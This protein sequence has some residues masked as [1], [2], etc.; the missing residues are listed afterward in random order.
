M[1][2]LMI[3]PFLNGYFIGKINPTFPDKPIFHIVMESG[4]VSCWFLYVEMGVIMTAMTIL[5]ENV[6]HVWTYNV[7]SP[8]Y[9][10][11]YKHRCL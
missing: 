8:S 10:V 11:V 6:A 7:V 1:V 9:K 4:H 5:P 3:I 2:L